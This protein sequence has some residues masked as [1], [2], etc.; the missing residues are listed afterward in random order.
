MSIE[1]YYSVLIYDYIRETIDSVV[2]IITDTGYIVLR[3]PGID[4][5]DLIIVISGTL[6]LFALRPVNRTKKFLLISPYYIHSL[7]DGINL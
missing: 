7:I 5:G 1:V 6:Y 3:P 2:F 4:T